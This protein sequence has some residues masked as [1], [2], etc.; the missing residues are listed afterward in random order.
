MEKHLNIAF[1][2][3]RKRPLFNITEYIGYY[4]MG[5]MYTTIYFIIL[6]THIYNI[7]IYVYVYILY[8]YICNYIYN[9]Y[10][11]IYIS[12]RIWPMPPTWRK[13]TADQSICIY[14]ALFA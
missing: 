12:P 7:Y 4:N 1:C 2:L 13:E 11:Y 10:T 14:I 5:M 6:F 8:I 9:I 3:L